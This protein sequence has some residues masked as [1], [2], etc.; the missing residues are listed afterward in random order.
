M[1]DF[2]NW[3]DLLEFLRAAGETDARN[4]TS[5][6]TDHELWAVAHRSQRVA[7][8]DQIDND[9]LAELRDAFNDGRQPTRFD[10]QAVV[11]EVARHGHDAHIG[12]SGGNTA[13]IYAGSQHTD[14]NGDAR[15]AVI[16]G[17]GWFTEPA[18]QA[19][20]AD[21]SE[22]QIG[23][24]DDYWTI[25]VPDHTSPTE[26]AALIVAVIEQIAAGQGRLT[27]S[28]PLPVHINGHEQSD[29]RGG[30]AN[31]GSGS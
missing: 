6:P 28:P 1:N 9:L 10:M 15:W 18:R 14:Q 19:P 7:L 13:T 4:G 29:A 27:E 30:R 3:L 22:F 8:P 23:P 24:D 11:V 17:P 26:V 2:P 5:L 16:A 25:A 12:H 20:V 31:A 21:T